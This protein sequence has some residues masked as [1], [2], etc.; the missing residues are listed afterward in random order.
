M[1]LGELKP[2]LAALLLPPAGPLLLALAGVLLATLPTALPG[3]GGD[4]R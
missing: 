4:P 1:A 2:V 3:G